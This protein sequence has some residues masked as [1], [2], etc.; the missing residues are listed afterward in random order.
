MRT[1]F[2]G[3]PLRQGTYFADGARTD[4][5]PVCYKVVGMPHILRLLRF[6]PNEAIP[7]LAADLPL[8]HLHG[9]GLS[10]NKWG[11]DP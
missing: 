10:A 1:N 3:T 9:P 5:I 4:P 2:K 8:Q 6:H 7:I 11:I